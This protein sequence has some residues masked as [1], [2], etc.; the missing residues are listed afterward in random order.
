MKRNINFLTLGAKKVKDKEKTIII[1]GE[2]KG[3]YTEDLDNRGAHQD[4][5]LNIRS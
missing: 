1:E 4:R 3:R 5:D 2:G